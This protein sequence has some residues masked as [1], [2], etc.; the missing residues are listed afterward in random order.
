MVKPGGTGSPILAISASP[1]P[2]PPRRSRISARPSALP[3]PNAYTHLRF[4]RPGAGRVER[5]RMGLCP[6]AFMRDRLGREF[7]FSSLADEMMNVIESDQANN[8]EI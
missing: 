3:L 8:D 5:L 7:V 1:A 2:L 6:C 4:A